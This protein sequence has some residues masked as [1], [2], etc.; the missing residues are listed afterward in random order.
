MWFKRLTIKNVGP[1]KHL[2]LTFKRGLIGVFGRNGSGKSTLL[3]LMY[4]ALTN[5]FS[6]FDGVKTDCINNTIG[7]KEESLLYAEVEHGGRLLKIT[8][9]LK[10][11]PLNELQIDDGEPL[12]N[13]EKVEE[14]LTETL[15]VDRKL[16]DLF[17]FKRQDRIY[18]FMV[19]TDAER[20]KAFQSLCQTE[21]CES[22]WETLG[23]HLNQDAELNTEIVDNSDE[24][25]GEL[26]ELNEQLKQ[27]ESE[28]SGWEGQLL[29]S[30]SEESAKDILRRQRK[31]EDL[32][33]E[34]ES[35]RAELPALRT[36]SQEATERKDKREGKLA[37]LVVR[38]KQLRPKAQAAGTALKAWTTYQ[39]QIAR[40]AQLE[41]K[42]SP[43]R[44]RRIRRRNHRSSSATTPSTRVPCESVRHV[45][46]ESLKWLRRS[47]R[48]SRPRA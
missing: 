22:L 37:E 25:A 15:G 41:E 8:R 3:D 13:S 27:L 44:A 11:K 14:K 46:V 23:E 30:K 7:D 26:G 40:K 36:A 35:K 17:C 39:K 28:R 10:G 19:S 31:V 20:K 33:E 6:R 38:H 2:D 16:L 21:V 32:V 4:A 12:T 47:W 29:N 43:S 5:D 48:R 24:L 45:C 1:H 18:D 34:R 42:P 9:R